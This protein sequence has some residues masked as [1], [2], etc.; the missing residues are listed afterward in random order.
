MVTMSAYPFDVLLPFRCIL[1]PPIPL[2]QCH[3]IGDVVCPEPAVRGFFCF[4]S[5]WLE[6]VDAAMFAKEGEGYCFESFFCR[7]F[8]SGRCVLSL[9]PQLLK[10]IGCFGCLPSTSRAR[11]KRKKEGSWWVR[12]RPPIIV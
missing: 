9:W 11:T 1:P 8:P 10:T 6:R 7:V 12:V 3:I 4:G 2:L 5:L